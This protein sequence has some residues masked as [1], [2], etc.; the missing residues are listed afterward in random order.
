M[1][2]YLVIM[3]IF[4]LPSIAYGWYKGLWKEMLYTVLYVSILG[5]I[6]DIISVTVFRLWYWNPDTII[7]IW[8]FGLPLEEYLFII[9]VP[10]AIIGLVLDKLKKLGK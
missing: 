8:L 1:Y 7:G 5:I 3:L 6:W 2:E 9:L 10:M 4:T